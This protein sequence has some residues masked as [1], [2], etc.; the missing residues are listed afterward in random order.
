MKNELNKNNNICITTSLGTNSMFYIMNLIKH[1][2][3][4]HTIL[5]QTNRYR[6]KREKKKLNKKKLRYLIPY[7]SNYLAF[8]IFNSPTTLKGQ[9]FYIFWKTN[10]GRKL[11]KLIKKKR[12]K[13]SNIDTDFIDIRQYE[14]DFYSRIDLIKKALKQ[15][16]F[17]S[18]IILTSKINGK[19]IEN[20]LFQNKI[21]VLFI[22]GG[23]IIRPNILNQILKST[24]TIHNSYLPYLRGWGGGEVWSLIHN[25]K[26]AL[27]TTIFYTDKGI[28]TGDILIQEHLKISKDD[29]LES[30]KY[31]NIILGKDLLIKA[32]NLLNSNCAPRIKQNSRKKTTINRRPFNEEIDLAN[33]NLNIWKSEISE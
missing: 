5:V 9:I 14:L 22:S 30:L 32:I 15:S 21:D 2:I 31:K 17:N 24:I 7:I 12:N 27:G 16:S 1:K 20:Y 25:Q 28:D 13:N 19:V 8:R 10:L 23:T 29:S 6:P 18:K 26:D 33:E 3:E 11:I 4:I